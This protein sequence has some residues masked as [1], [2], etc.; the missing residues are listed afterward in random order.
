MKKIIYASLIIISACQPKSIEKIEKKDNVIHNKVIS[1]LSKDYE[2][3]E[4]V[5]SLKY[6]PDK[7]IVLKLKTD[8][9]NHL[10]S[11]T[12]Y[13]RI[14]GQLKL[15][16]K[17]DSLNFQ[18]GIATPKFEDF[19]RDGVND[20]NIPYG[21]GGRG[22]NRFSYAFLQNK[23]TG[24][25]SYIDESDVI[26]N[27]HY[28]S[29]RNVISSISLYA[30]TTFIDYKLENNKLIKS[31]GV[32]VST[33]DEWTYREYYKFDNQGNKFINK[34]DSINDQGEGLFNRE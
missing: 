27:L 17:I 20:I 14:N 22:G 16:Q 18:F 4:F 15:F 32:D 13:Q 5:D 2:K 31:E 25:L 24:K 19:N 12:L 10:L 11:I 33:N 8:E 30:G 26:P 29:I 9:A 28:D 34:K 6:R 23:N 21:T 1:D 3:N 7:N